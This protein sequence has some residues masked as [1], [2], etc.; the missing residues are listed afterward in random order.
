ME[1][2]YYALTETSREAAW[3]RL[4]LEELSY[5]KLDAHLTRSFRDNLPSYILT[6]N[7]E[8]HQKAKYIRIAYHYVRDE[9]LEGN[10]HIFYIPTRLMTADGLT[11]I[12]HATLFATFVEM[13]RLDT[14]S[15]NILD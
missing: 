12:L 14:W 13:L 7:P 2:K 6:N 15:T 10:A 3:L 11:K 9:I 4:L 8:F 5:G 1:S